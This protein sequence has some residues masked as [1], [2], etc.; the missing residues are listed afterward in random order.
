MVAAQG[1]SSAELEHYPALPDFE[2]Q[3]LIKVMLH[4]RDFSRNTKE[5]NNGARIA[6]GEGDLKNV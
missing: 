2:V 1:Q 3:V 6:G 5:R 4:C